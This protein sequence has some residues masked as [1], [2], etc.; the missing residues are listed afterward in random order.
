LQPSQQ[1]ETGW[2]TIEFADLGSISQ[3]SFTGNFCHG[4]ERSQMTLEEVLDEVTNDLDSGDEDLGL[5]DD[6]ENHDQDDSD[7]EYD[8]VDESES[9]DDGSPPRPP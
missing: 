6:W 1:S 4:S 7:W 3:L 5:G 9:D 2:S 8:H